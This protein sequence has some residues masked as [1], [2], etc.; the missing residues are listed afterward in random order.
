MM[1][2]TGVTRLAIPEVA[3]I[4]FARF[5][6]P[7]GFFPEH[8]RGSDLEGHWDLEDR[9]GVGFCKMNEGFSRTGTIRGLL[10]QW[11]PVMGKLVRPVF[12]R[13]IDLVLDIR[14]GPP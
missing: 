4:R 11:N 1:K 10:F 3:V 12:G 6:D 9:R 8:Y 2:I 5:R 14:K 13:L 7:R